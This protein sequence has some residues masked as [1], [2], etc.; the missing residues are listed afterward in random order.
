MHAVEWEMT[1]C[2]RRAV[3]SLL[4]E[5]SWWDGHSAYNRTT[6]LQ[7]SSKWWPTDRPGCCWFT[8]LSERHVS[9]TNMIRQQTERCTAAV[10]CWND[11]P[12]R[13]SPEPCDTASQPVEQRF[14]DWRDIRWC[15][16]RWH[17]SPLSVHRCLL[18]VSVVW[19]VGRQTRSLRPS[20][21]ARPPNSCAQANDRRPVGAAKLSIQGNECVYPPLK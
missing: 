4:R 20:D 14:D 7:E 18:A 10:T 21:W 13:S 6:T 9:H 15:R 1:Q 12:V 19:L 5:C 3:A 2:G 16:R 17:R 11:Y 8:A